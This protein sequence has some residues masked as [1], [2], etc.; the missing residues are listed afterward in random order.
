MDCCLASSYHLGNEDNFEINLIAMLLSSLTLNN[1]F[2][3][4]INVNESRVS[5]QVPE[6]LRIKAMF[7]YY[8][9]KN[10][11]EVSNTMSNEDKPAILHDFWI[12]SRWM[13]IHIDVQMRMRCIRQEFY[14]HKVLT[15]F[16]H[17]STY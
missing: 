11:I 13:E 6:F 17:F 1:T 14:I 5:F 10:H 4:Q 16:F 12:W 7:A 9:T 3:L 15:F 2:C 8:I